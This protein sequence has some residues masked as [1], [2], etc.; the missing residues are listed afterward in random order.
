M[1]ESVIVIE[2]L[3][4]G[5]TLHA[6]KFCEVNNRPVACYY[7][8]NMQWNEK[9]IGNKILVESKRAMAINEEKDLK[10]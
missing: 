10:N 6:V 5:G 3:T 7:S 1:S 8:E 2:T 9:N 4:N